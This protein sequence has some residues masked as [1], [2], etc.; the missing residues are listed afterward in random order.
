MNRKDFQETLGDLK[1]VMDQNLKRRILNSVNLFRTWGESR[2]NGLKICL[3]STFRKGDNICE[4]GDKA[5]EF[6]VIG[7]G[8]VDIVIDDKVVNS[9]AQGET[10]GESAVQS[11]SEQGTR[12]ATVTAVTDEVL[13]YYV[14]NTDWFN[15][16]GNSLKSMIASEQARREAAMNKNNLYKS[17]KLSDLRT[18]Q[19]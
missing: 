8:K 7:D 5:D 19:C 11:K 14:S 15:I 3:N 17:L 16:I 1:E 2:R 13:I 4:N 18:L 6:Y 9:L 12:N 10:F